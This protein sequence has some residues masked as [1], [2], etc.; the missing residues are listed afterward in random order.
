MTMS[1]LFHGRLISSASKRDV[2][3][4]QR[5]LNKYKKSR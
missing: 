1:R 5:L 2:L 4:D 3:H